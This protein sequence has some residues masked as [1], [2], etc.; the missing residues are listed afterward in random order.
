MGRLQIG[1]GQELMMH[2]QYCR[3]VRAIEDNVWQIEHIN[4]GRY[5]SL[6]TDEILRLYVEKKLRPANDDL[7]APKVSDKK[8]REGKIVWMDALPEKLREKSIVR[9]EYVMAVRD[10]K[11]RHF[12]E[13]TL[14]PIIDEVYRRQKDRGIDIKTPPSWSSV[15]R[16]RKRFYKAGQ[17]IR[18]LVD[19][20][21]KKGNR[22][23]R[24]PQDLVDIAQRAINDTYLTREKGTI[25]DTLDVAIAMVADENI[26]RTAHTRLPMP[27]RSLVKRLIDE[28]D[29]YDVTL[30]REGREI[31]EMKYRAAVN[32]I[33]AT[34]ILEYVQIDHTILDLM[35]IDEYSFLPIGR[36]TLTVCIDVKSRAIL[37]VYVGFEPPSFVSV[38][39]CLKHAF[40]PKIDLNMRYPSIK[41]E[42]VAFGIPEH[43][44]M[45]N[46]MEF[47]SKDLENLCFNFGVNMKFMKRK[48]PWFKPH[49]ERFIG[50]CNRAVSHIT[51]GTTFSNIFERGD[52]KSAKKAVM[53]LSS[54]REMLFKWV[55][56]VYHNKPHKGL[57]GKTPDE[58]WQSMIN[59]RIA[60]MP[61]N[62]D[63]FDGL[64]GGVDERVVTHK[65]IEFYWLRY[66]SLEL[67][68]MRQRHGES[69]KATIRYNPTDIREVF[70]EDPVTKRLLR[71]PVVGDEKIKYTEGLSLWQHKVICRQAKKTTWRPTIEALARSKAE[72]R[73]IIRKDMFNKR[74]KTRSNQ[75]RHNESFESNGR[76][77]RDS[78]AHPKNR[79]Q[80]QN[81]VTSLPDNS[82]SISTDNDMVPDFH[83]TS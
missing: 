67:R 36:P 34:N 21:D 39:Q 37:G 32:E 20:N 9:Y 69:F 17:D 1:R 73:E 58:V 8:L 18:A 45:D 26:F 38:A 54:F 47:H 2:G 53:T 66:N 56:D 44:V 68:E 11:L 50:T 14:K 72:I 76:D 7:M 71:V 55:V 75:A 74:L 57:G 83:V 80:Y 40:M 59:G 65:G 43:L 35:L 78:L 70:V 64:M 61:G 60:P 49:I 28:I 81:G 12:T 77:D 51:P 16:W 52:Y 79:E 25:Q 23:Q 31:A 19:Q 24:Y 27:T 33:V 42:W 30:A 13:K 3:V 46:G 63:D 5:E 10:A 4:T 82:Q 41:G 6:T 29:K 22:T 15:N 48:T 62:P